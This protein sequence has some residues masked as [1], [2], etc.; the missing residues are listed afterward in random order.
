MPLAD[1]PP[2]S[3]FAGNGRAI[4]RWWGAAPAIDAGWGRRVFLR[5]FLM[6]SLLGH[7]GEDA[8]DEAELGGKGFANVLFLVVLLGVI[9]AIALVVIMVL[10]LDG[11]FLNDHLRPLT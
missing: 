9:A 3:R 2:G 8:R 4:G 6:L 10:A 7:I 1:S 11:H 5:L